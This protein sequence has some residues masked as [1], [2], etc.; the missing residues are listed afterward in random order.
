MS[1]RSVTGFLR[2][3]GKVQGRALDCTTFFHKC[4]NLTCL[5]DESPSNTQAYLANCFVSQLVMSCCVV[6]PDRQGA[7]APSYKDLTSIAVSQSEM[8]KNYRCL[9]GMLTCGSVSIGKSVLYI[10]VYS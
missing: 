8:H 7:C 3:D 1:A 5:V 9:P 10:K 4:S 2:Q 6:T